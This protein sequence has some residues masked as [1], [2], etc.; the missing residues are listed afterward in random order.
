MVYVRFFRFNAKRISRQRRYRAGLMAKEQQPALI[1]QR[2]RVSSR[3]AECT[4]EPF[5]F[6]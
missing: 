6:Q 2:I 4:D 5:I 1:K 3:S